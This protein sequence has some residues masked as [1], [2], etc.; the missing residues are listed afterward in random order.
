[1]EDT[2]DNMTSIQNKCKETSNKD[3]GKVEEKND[4]K[5]PNINIDKVQ[6]LVVDKENLVKSTENAES[7]DDNIKAL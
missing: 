1:M 3:E 2:E 7:S 6:D 5:D 4:N